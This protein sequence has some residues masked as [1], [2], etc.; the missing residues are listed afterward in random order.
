[1]KTVEQK[2]MKL[3]KTYKVSTNKNYI[4]V[5]LDNYKENYYYYGRFIDKHQTFEETV[6]TIY[7]ELFPGDE[8]NGSY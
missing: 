4:K 3:C 5:T 7:R 8:D 2:L 6:E 1:M